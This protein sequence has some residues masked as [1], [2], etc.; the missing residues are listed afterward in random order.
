MLSSA[1]LLGAGIF[2]VL[3]QPWVATHLCILNGIT[4]LCGST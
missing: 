1:K 4:G 3:C 2:Q